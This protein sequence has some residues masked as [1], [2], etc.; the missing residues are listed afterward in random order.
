M[1]AVR[2]YITLELLFFQPPKPILLYKDIVDAS[3]EGPACPL[4]APK[5]YF[6]SEDCLTINVY[7]PNT[8]R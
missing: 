8:K 5:E 3:E 4:L 1:I 6:V 7:T 2:F